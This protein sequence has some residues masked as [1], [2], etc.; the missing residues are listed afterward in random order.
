MHRKTYV[1]LV[2]IWLTAF[3]LATPY[4]Y[5]VTTQPLWGDEIMQ[6]KRREKSKRFAETS[7]Q[8][9]EDW[10]HMDPAL[11]RAVACSESSWE[12]VPLAPFINPKSFTIACLVIQVV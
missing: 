9:L 2:C 10:C 8:I 4:F 11:A 12:T 1:T 3:F 5:A 7:P 6:V